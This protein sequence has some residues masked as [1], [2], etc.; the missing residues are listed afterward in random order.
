[1]ANDTERPSVERDFG[2]TRAMT[3]R[4]LVVDDKPDV[5]MLFRQQFAAYTTGVKGW[6]SR[7]A[8]SLHWP[9]WTT[10]AARRSSLWVSDI[11]MPDMSGLVLLRTPRPERPLF[12]IPTYGDAATVATALARGADK[13]LTKRVHFPKLKQDIMAVKADVMRWDA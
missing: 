7:F 6:T 4:V 13:F 8:P 5:E 11:N 1:M 3:V 2:R 10:P 9:F 12:T